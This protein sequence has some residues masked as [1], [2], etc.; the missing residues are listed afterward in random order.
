MKQ[1]D[2]RFT[3]LAK[4]YM[5]K[6]GFIQIEVIMDGGT[7]IQPISELTFLNLVEEMGIYD[8]TLYVVRL[9][10]YLTQLA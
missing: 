3:Q 2:K 6:L 8:A 1:S 7:M 10:K 9:F 4:S 5:D